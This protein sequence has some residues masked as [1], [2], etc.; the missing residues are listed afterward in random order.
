MWYSSDELAALALPG[1]PRTRRNVDLLAER[2]GWRAPEGEHPTNPAG[3]WRRRAGRGGGVEYSSAALPQKAR[4]AL[5][6]R[7]AKSGDA[8]VSAEAAA[9]RHYEAARQRLKDEAK[10]RLEALDAVAALEATGVQRDVALARIAHD[11]NVSLRTLYNWAALTLGRPRAHW[12]ALLTPAYRGREA[13]TAECPED[14][15]ASLKADYLRLSQPSFASCYRRL[16]FAAKRAGVTLPAARTLERRLLAETPAEVLVRAREGEEALKRLYP[17]QRRDRSIFHALEAVNTDGHT[18]DVF[19]KTE[20]GRIIRPVLVPMHDL[21]S[22]KIVSWRLAESENRVAFMLAFGDM[23]EAWGV[24]DRI[25]IDNTRAAANKWVT[26]G[27]PNRYR[28]KVREDEPVGLLVTMGVDVH[29]T[30]PGSG[31][32]KPIERAFR[33][34]CDDIAKHP[35][36]EGAYTGNSPMA[37]PENYGARAVAWAEFERL[38]GQQIAAW[39]ARRGRDTKACG[40][41]L[42]FDEAFA[43]SYAQSPIRKAS[44]EQRRLWLLAVEALTVRDGDATL[45]LLGNR[46]WADFLVGLRGQRVTARFDPANLH[47]PLHVYAQDGRYLGQADCIADTGFADADAA[48]THN[49]ARRDWLKAVKAQA[50]AEKRMGAQDRSPSFLD[51]IAPP[52][53]AATAPSIIRPVFG[54]LALKSEPAP[55]AERTLDA[56]ERGVVALFPQRGGASPE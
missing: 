28:F 18:F 37:K 33:D 14:L 50:D 27:L 53:P 40:G 6:L 46:Y 55:D 35:L 49:R 8:P 21:Y 2:E 3:W 42:S 22:G 17:A 36:C 19:V 30:R 20:E 34:L 9:W 39:N 25:W 56:F 4:A 5:A 13:R 26:G 38:V 45:H 54:S 29:W 1:L 47:A 11:L 48:R 16:E 7:E 32:S 31:Q 41:E 44:A 23:V 24:P 15:W 51:D 12:L 43:A 10:R 52:P